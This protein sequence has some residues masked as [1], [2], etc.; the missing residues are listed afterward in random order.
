MG[1]ELKSALRSRDDVDPGDTWDLSQLFTSNEAW[2]SLRW[3]TE[4][5]L[6]ELGAFEGRL[7]ESPETLRSFLD[8]D[9]ELRQA[10]LRVHHYASRLSDQDNANDTAQG[11]RQQANALRDQYE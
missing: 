11:M 6:G 4:A 10:V 2:E 7:S 1:M 5:R 3:E 8:L 9:M